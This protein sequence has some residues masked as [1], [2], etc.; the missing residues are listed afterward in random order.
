MTPIEAV[1]LFQRWGLTGAEAAQLLGRAY[2]TVYRWQRMARGAEPGGTVPIDDPFWC[3]VL[4]A[5]D[6]AE[7][8][9]K[10]REAL[11]CRGRA[12]AYLY[13]LTAHAA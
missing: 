6:A 7:H 5:L 1:A 9:A 3:H 11:A 12:G 4:A 13:L 2:T 8:G 10:L